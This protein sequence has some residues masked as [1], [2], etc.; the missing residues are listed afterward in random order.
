VMDW[1]VLFA[2]LANRPFLK[3]VLDNV[4]EVDGINALEVSFRCLYLGSVGVC[5]GSHDL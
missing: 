4:F 2:A 5:D 1:E 3:I